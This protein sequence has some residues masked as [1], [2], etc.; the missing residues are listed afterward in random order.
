MKAGSWSASMGRRRRRSHCGGQPTRQ[1]SGAW[2]WRSF[3][4]G[5]RTTCCLPTAG[6]PTERHSNWRVAP[7]SMMP[8]LRCRDARPCHRMSA[9]CWPRMTPRPPCCAWQRMPR[10]WWSVLADAAALPGSCWAR[11]ANA[12]SIM[13]RV[14]WQSSRRLGTARHTDV[15]SS[16]SMAP[17]PRT[18]RCIGR[19]LKRRDVR[20][21]STS[22]TPTASTSTLR[23]MDRSSR[24]TPVKWRSRA[25]QYSTRW[26]QARSEAPVHPRPSS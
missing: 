9:R 22:S 20:L 4:H 25:R 2:V 12:A 8:S 1:S 15:W 7:S 21:N 23:R 13:R 19:S 17:M 26:S 3:T 16:V 6:T 10:C 14:R 11:S 5:A 18:A 24:S